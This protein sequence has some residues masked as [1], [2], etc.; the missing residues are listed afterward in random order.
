[1]SLHACSSFSAPP[2]VPGLLSLYASDIELWHWHPNTDTKTIAA[3][4]LTTV[5]AIEKIVFFSQ[6]R[7]LCSVVTDNIDVTT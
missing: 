4:A 5:I 7:P 2:M 6:T 1:M 3:I